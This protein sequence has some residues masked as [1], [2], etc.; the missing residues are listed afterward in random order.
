[1][2]NKPQE[3]IISKL[4][5]NE[6]ESI[7]TTMRAIDGGALGIAFMVNEDGKFQGLVTDGDIRGAIL[8]GV[9]IESPVNM[10][11]C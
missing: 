6:N 10:I 5:V 4:T 11:K 1:M 7:K 3:G 9:M 2:I 8:H